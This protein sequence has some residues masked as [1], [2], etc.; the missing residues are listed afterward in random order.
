MTDLQL[1]DRLTNCSEVLGR[2]AHKCPPIAELA[3]L[4]E[5]MLE[6]AERLELFPS[7]VSLEVAK[8]LRKEMQ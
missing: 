5:V 2:A 1:A 6:C 4:R 3:R 7:M 8:L